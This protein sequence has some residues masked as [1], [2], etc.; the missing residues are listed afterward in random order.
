MKTTL[1]QPLSAG[2]VMMELSSLSFLSAF[3]KYNKIRPKQKQPPRICGV[4]KIPIISCVNAFAYDLSGF[5]ARILSPLTGNSNLTVENSGE[6]ASIIS[7]ETIHTDE[8]MLSFGVESLFTNVPIEDAVQA[9]LQRLHNDPSL[10]D[11][12]TLTPTQIADLL[13]FVL[14]STYFKYKGSLYEQQEG[15]P[16]SSS[17]TDKFKSIAALP[18]IRGVSETLRRNL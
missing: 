2:R 3:R 5:L 13:N 9:A 10:P 1:A 17:L 4:P 12:T 11:R 8:V 18:Y 6:F 14:K 15:A 16:M 7:Q